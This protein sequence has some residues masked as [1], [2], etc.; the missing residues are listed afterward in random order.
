MSFSEKLTTEI[1]KHGI[2]QE[3]EYSIYRYGV[4]ILSLKILAGMIAFGVSLL[5][6]TTEY[7]ALLLFFL[8][9]I[10]KYAGGIHA[11]NKWICLLFTELILLIGEILLLSGGFA[12]I[13]ETVFTVLGM[14]S[15]LCLAPIGSANRKLTEYQKKKYRKKAILYAGILNGLRI[16]QSAVSIAMLIESLLLLPSQLSKSKTQSPM[17][18]SQ[19]E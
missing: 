14:L 2:I 15:I 13:L 18:P 8:I 16:L 11:P 7:L 12:P 3:S 4:E 1:S 17:M 6:K 19:N 9:P 10:R 5:L